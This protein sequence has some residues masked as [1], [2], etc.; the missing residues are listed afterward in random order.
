[1]VQKA[2]TTGIALTAVGIAMLGAAFYFAYSTY[3][4]FLPAALSITS[5]S[6]TNFTGSLSGLLDAAIVVMFLGIMG[7]IG[8]IVLL[9]G[10]DFMKV[11][12][13]IGIMTFKLDKTT[14]I[15]SAIEMMSGK[16][17]AES[18]IASFGMGNREKS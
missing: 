15:V 2:G 10:V 4:S 9:R 14:G 1:M 7:W 5:G 11:D 18:P 8:S 6:S 16:S 13:G 17:P 3:K 12:K